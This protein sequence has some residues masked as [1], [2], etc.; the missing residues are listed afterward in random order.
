ML[1]FSVKSDP[2][3]L[4]TDA[5]PGDANSF[6]ESGRTAEDAAVQAWMPYRIEVFIQ[7]L[8]ILCAFVSLCSIK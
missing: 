7:F 5:L 8:L 2:P 1:F 4:S 3:G 6:A